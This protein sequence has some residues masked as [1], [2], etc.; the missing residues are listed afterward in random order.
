MTGIN[1]RDPLVDAV[2]ALTAETTE[3]LKVYRGAK[4]ELDEKIASATG[5]ANIATEKASE[6]AALAAK[7][8]SEAAKATQISGLN[9]VDAALAA[10]EGEFV[11]NAVSNTTGSRM[12]QI[13]DGNGNYNT[14][15]SIP[16]FTFDDVGMGDLMGTGVHPAFLRQNGTVIPEVWIGAYTAANKSNNAIVQGGLD[17]WNYINFDDAKAKCSAM[18]AGWHMMTAMEWSAVALWCLANG[19]QP[20][21]NTEYGRNHAKKFQSCKRMDSKAPNDRTG[22]P[23]GLCGTGPDSWRHDGTPFG[24]SDL[25]GNVWEWID[26]FKLVDNKLH[27]SSFSGQ[28]ESDWT[29]TDIG[30]TSGSGGAWGSSTLSGS[31]TTLKQMLIEKIDATNTLQGNLWHTATGERLPFRGGDWGNGSGCGVGALNLGN[32]RSYR[33]NNI[34]FRPAFIAV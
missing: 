15:V 33:N 18:G 7:A 5:S 9:N 24:I 3:L 22:T 10:R 14:M 26:G 28:P 32:E 23:R 2:G 4:T 25:V 21:G 8:T 12:K 20:G 19:F 1:E 11:G 16:C 30:I 17:P 34:G 29:S 13:L 31:N 6:A 27:V